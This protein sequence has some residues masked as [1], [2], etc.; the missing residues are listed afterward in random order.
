MKMKLEEAI[1]KTAV[2]AQIAQKRLPVKVGYAVSRNYEKLSK[3]QGV[4]DT[5]RQKL[6][7]ELSEKGEDGNPVMLK[8]VI[9]GKPVE[10]FKLSDDALAALSSDLQEILSTE[11]EVDILTIGMDALE[12]ID[13][14]PRYEALSPGEIGALGFMITEG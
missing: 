8:S 5:Q 13:E 3:E 14:D 6:C 9:D 4:F 2:L 7:K 10:S 11:I 12:R 1:T